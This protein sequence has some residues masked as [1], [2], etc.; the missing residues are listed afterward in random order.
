MSITTQPETRK[1]CSASLAVPM[2]CLVSPCEFDIKDPYMVFCLHQISD[3]NQ[4]KTL[5]VEMLKKYS[6]LH[7]STLNSS[8]S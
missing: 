8:K 6:T 1:Y 7:T 4:I 2:L 5:A 3:D